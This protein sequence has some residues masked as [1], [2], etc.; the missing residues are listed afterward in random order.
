[1]TD[2]DRKIRA[3]STRLRIV[4]LVYATTRALFYAACLAVLV[5]L[6]ERLFAFRFNIWAVSGIL[7]GICLPV[8]LVYALLVRRAAYRAAVAADESVRLEERLSSA[9]LLKNQQSDP[10]VGLLLKDATETARGLKPSR[11]LP[12]RF[13]REARYLF[14]P[15]IAFGILYF[16]PNLDLLGRDAE[17]KQVIEEKKEVMRVG[18]NLE[19]A[20]A[21]I[22]RQAEKNELEETRDLSQE[23][24]DLQWKLQKG[25]I[26]RKQGLAKVSSLQDKVDDVRKKYE[27]ETRSQR[28][29]RQTSE[30]KYS[31]QMADAMRRG[32]FQKALDEMQRLKEQVDSGQM[33][34]R[35]QEQLK[36]EL[37]QISRQ[38]SNQSQ[39]LSKA[40]AEASKSLN[41]ENSQ[42]QQQQEQGQN[43]EGPNQQPGQDQQQQGQSPD[44][45]DQQD[46]SGQQNGFEQA[47]QELER[48]ARMQEDMKIMEDL[49]QSCQSTKESLGG[50]RGATAQSGQ[51]G[52][53]TSGQ[54]GQEGQGQ[55]GQSGQPQPVAASK[56]GTDSSGQKPG[57]CP[58]CNSRGCPG[59][60][61]CQGGNQGGSQ[62]TGQWTTGDTAQKGS[63][64]GG[65]GIGQGG[66]LPEDPLDDS[67]V[68]FTEFNAG[69]QFD[70]EANPR[71]VFEVEADPLESESNIG[72]VETMRTFSQESEDALDREEVPVG[73]ED[74]VR[75]YFS[76][77]DGSASVDN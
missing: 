47:S 32:D 56:P 30:M 14:A 3:L 55:D 29:I 44:D 35:E 77:I 37:E 73:Y 24:R 39:E 18:E 33:D 48:L 31:R 34:S 45:Q 11:A 6:V 62:Q 36:R 64:M 7:A 10:M 74:L 8:G 68:D 71:A 16:V 5:L 52:A 72:S 51:Q 43:R 70:Q 49:S 26:D 40:F 20:V 23:L 63:G 27:A 25:E 50:K 69:G 54:Q 38:T 59:G 21:R 9:W 22:E 19:R 53:E 41:N 15:L 65:A 76:T 60:S 13:S 61:Q 4:R 2:L 67:P 42:E 57:V 12:L 28:G 46:Q 66:Q 1:M 17:A 75:S 58:K